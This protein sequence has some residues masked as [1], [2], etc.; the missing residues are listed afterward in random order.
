MKK[1][2]TKESNNSRMLTIIIIAIVAIIV[3]LT[4]VFVVANKIKKPIKEEID[5]TQN[6]VEEIKEYNYNEGVIEDK[7]VKGIKFTNVNCYWD[8]VNSNISYIVTNTTDKPVKIGEY[9]IEAYDSSD[10]LFYILSPYMD[11]EL[12]PGESY[13]DMISISENLGSANSIKIFIES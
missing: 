8:G 9:T 4:V 5:N 6:Q 2:K 7:E 10:N 13:Q 11:K 12:A 3:I 1:E